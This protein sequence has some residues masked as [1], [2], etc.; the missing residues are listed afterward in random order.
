[1]EQVPEPGALVSERQYPALGATELLLGNGLRVLIKET[2]HLEDEVL[3]TGFARGGLS[4]VGGRCWGYCGVLYTAVSAEEGWARRAPA[5]VRA[6]RFRG[7][8]QLTSCACAGLVRWAACWLHSRQMPWLAPWL[9]CHDR[10]TRAQS[11]PAAAPTALGAGAARPVHHVQPGA[12]GG[13]AAGAVRPQANHHQ[14]DPGGW[15]ARAHLPSPGAST[16]L[17]SVQGR[18]PVVCWAPSMACVCYRGPRHGCAVCAA[19]L[20]MMLQHMTTHA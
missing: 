13:G 2:E 11:S 8:L 5:A 16:A 17:W 15:V 12:A 20:V 9:A 1:M 10:A 14:R 6:Q 4:Q 7:I 3:L 19:R 18:C